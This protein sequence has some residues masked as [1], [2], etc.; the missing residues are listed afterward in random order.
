MLEASWLRPMNVLLN[1]KKFSLALKVYYLDWNN[2]GNLEYCED[3]A[4]NSKQMFH[5]FCTY[6][7]IFLFFM[8]QI[9]LSVLRGTQNNNVA[10]LLIE[11][12]YCNNSVNL[13]VPESNKFRAKWH[14]QVNCSV[15][16]QYASESTF[17][18]S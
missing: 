6:A 13:N 17:F 10:E 18:V 9:D 7:E 12:F 5:L 4:R 15:L 14:C 8:Y 3:W 11:S 1:Q 16:F 2:A